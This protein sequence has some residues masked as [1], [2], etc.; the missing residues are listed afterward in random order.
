MKRKSI[1]K[2]N[3]TW[4]SISEEPFA[5]LK[6]ESPERETDVSAELLLLP[7]LTSLGVTDGKWSLIEG[8]EPTPL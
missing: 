4:I 2:Q 8:T 1:E 7:L 5:A 6:L 3:L